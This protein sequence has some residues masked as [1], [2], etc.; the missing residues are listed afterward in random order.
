MAGDAGWIRLDIVAATIA[1]CTIWR[2]ICATLP[3]E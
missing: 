2:R 3:E 1:E